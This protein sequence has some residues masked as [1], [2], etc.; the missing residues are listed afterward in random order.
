MQVSQLDHWRMHGTVWVQL[1]V[2]ELSFCHFLLLWLYFLYNLFWSCFVCK[3]WCAMWIGLAA[4][5]VFLSYFRLLFLFVAIRCS[6]EEHKKHVTSIAF[7]DVNCSLE[8]VEMNTN[9][10]YLPL[11]SQGLMQ[12]LCICISDKTWWM[13]VLVVFLTSHMWVFPSAC[14]EKN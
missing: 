14:F 6:F 8:T 10:I 1:H 13:H 5:N 3:A 7:T 4:G 11:F 2:Q 9:N 12:N